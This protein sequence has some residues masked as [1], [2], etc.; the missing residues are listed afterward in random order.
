MSNQIEVTRQNLQEAVVRLKESLEDYQL[1][2]L[3]WISD[4][5]SAETELSN[6]IKKMFGGVGTVDVVVETVGQIKLKIHTYTNTSDFIVKFNLKSNI[7]N[8]DFRETVDSCIKNYNLE[9]ENTTTEGKDCKKF[10]SL[11]RKNYNAIEGLLTA[12]LNKSFKVQ[13]NRI[14]ATDDYD[15]S[16]RGIKEGIE[17]LKEVL[18][19]QILESDTS[20]RFEIPL[21]YDYRSSTTA[22]AYLLVDNF[23]KGKGGQYR[24][25]I[26]EDVW[27]KFSETISLDEESLIQKILSEAINYY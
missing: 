18:V 3:G 10:F 11:L 8:F 21:P 16:H 15:H 23:T 14:Y 13:L 20:C 5:K 12:C 27:Y 17:N 24:M 7:S 6:A 2:K 4:I 9:L 26:R 22:R 19:R 1:A 25:E